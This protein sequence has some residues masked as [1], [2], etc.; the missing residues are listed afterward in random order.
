LSFKNYRLN[1]DLLSLHENVQITQKGDKMYIRD[2]IRKKNLILKPEELVRQ[3]LILHLIQNIKISI[4][5]IQ[6]EKKL[7]INGL[8][9]RFDV[10]VYD[11][12]VKP[13]ILIECKASS[14]KISQQTF[15]QVAA[16][17]FAVQAPFIIVSNGQETY[18]AWVD[19]DTKSYAFL[20]EIPSV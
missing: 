9:R 13:Y 10:V 3:I 17:N 8:L 7:N 14:V 12:D 6:V 1:I 11:K 18:C 5:Q 2:I 20:S 16:Y 4:G 19:H 15:D